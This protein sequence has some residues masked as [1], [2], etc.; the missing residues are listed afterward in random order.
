[1]LLR[2]VLLTRAIRCDRVSDWP[3]TKKKPTICVPTSNDQVL[4]AVTLCHSVLRI[5]FFQ[6]SQCVSATRLEHTSHISGR[7]RCLGWRVSNSRECGSV[8]LPA[9]GDQSVWSLT[10]PPTGRTGILRLSFSFESSHIRYELPL[11]DSYFFALKVLWLIRPS[12]LILNRL[13]DH[14]WTWLA[15]E[16]GVT[17][18][19]RQANLTPLR[20]LS[21]H[22]KPASCHTV[23][24]L[25]MYQK[26]SGSEKE[27]HSG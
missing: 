7:I 6:R 8:I 21:G 26:T 5:G 23:C 24:L 14:A 9:I 20:S 27:A 1:M 17:M 22:L 4:V 18:Q 19:R 25:R 16:N 10:K 15:H 3:L 2:H 11:G 12:M 13:I